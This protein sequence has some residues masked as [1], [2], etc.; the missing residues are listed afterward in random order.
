[1]SAPTPAHEIPAAILNVGDELLAGDV[2]NTNAAFLARC[3]REL[4][5]SVVETRVVR[6]R[7]DEIVS[8]ISDLSRLGTACWVSGGLGPTS[9]DLTTEA[10][11]RAAGVPLVRDEGALGR[12]EEKFRRFGRPMADANRKQADFPRGARLLLNPIGTAEGFAVQIGG[13]RFF[14]MPGVPR[15]LELMM[16]E[17]VEPELRAA[18][19][20]APV[21][22]RIYR[23]LGRGESSLAETLASLWSSL[24]QRSP[25]LGST[26]IHYRAA[27]PEVQIIVEATPGPRGERAT[28][29]ELRSLDTEVERLVRP[30]LFGIGSASLAARVLAASH[31]A[32]L[33]LCTAESCTG[34]GIGQRLAAV[35]GA[36]QSFLGGIIAYDDAIKSRQLGVPR[37]LLAQHGAVSEPVAR[38]MAEGARMATGADLSLAVTGI[39]GPSGGSLEKPVGTVHVA[40]ADAEGTVHERLH[41]RGDRGTVQK[42]TEQWALKVLWDRLVA[43]GLAAIEEAEAP[44]PS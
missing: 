14:V 42:S 43:R 34:G 28:A 15:E 17:Q 1:M 13:C 21:L 32:G 5:F 31:R 16:H 38:A 26:F 11:A 4:G 37:T 2:I 27:T 33:K 9:D 7:V 24:P 30:A 12:L 25:G 3:A 29:D 39:A 20:C 35:P 6:D 8:N 36:S 41:L 22:R 23:T 18:F 44:S 19:G 40:V 10:F